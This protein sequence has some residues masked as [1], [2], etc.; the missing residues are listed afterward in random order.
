MSAYLAEPRL[1][2]VGTNGWAGVAWH[3]VEVIAETPK[4]YRVRGRG[5]QAITIAA[6]RRLRAGQSTLVPKYAVR[7]VEQ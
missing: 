3:P 1:A 5:G 6:N 2:E 4:R 7:F